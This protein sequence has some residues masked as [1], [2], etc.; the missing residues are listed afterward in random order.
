MVQ[1]RCKVLMVIDNFDP[2][3]AQT[4]LLDLAR[5]LDRERFEVLIAPLRQPR[6]YAEA[7]ADCGARVIPLRGGKFNPFKLFGLIWLIHRER[8]DVV[9]THLMASRLLGVVA[10]RLAGA[11]K[12][13][14]HDHSGDE[15]LRR[16]QRLAR[17]LIYPLDRLL[18]RFTD[19]ILAVSESVAEFN[20]RFKNIPAGKVSVLHNWIDLERF[21]P[22]SAERSTLRRLWGL[23]EDAFVVG[24]VGRLSGQKGYRYLVEAAPRILSGRPDTVF[25]VVGEGEDRGALERLAAT[26]GVA[27]SF[28][29]PGFMVEVENAYPVFDLF[30]LPSIYEPFGLAVLEA[31][32]AGLTVVAAATGGLREI[33]EDETTGLLVPPGDAEALARGVL[34]LME[35]WES[36]ARPMAERGRQQV[37]RRFGRQGAIARIEALYLGSEI[38]KAISS[39]D[40]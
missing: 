3:G 10:G 14:S 33:V 28:R 32:A 12:I 36:S 18:M 30:V 29:F 26:L 22:R 16:K 2:G 37:H 39:E 9:H 8:V 20:V 4:L 21:S 1:S 35:H 40:P 34:H 7:L 13:F 38:F 5:G 15:Y 25:V 31:M 6:A 24:S 11:G 23:P 19:R 17:W 27:R